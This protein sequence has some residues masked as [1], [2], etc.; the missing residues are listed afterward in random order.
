MGGELRRVRLRLVTVV[1]MI[2][3][4]VSSGAFGIEDMV[5]ESGPGMTMLL[6]LVLP[7]VWGLPMAL[8]CSELGS[9]IPEEGGYYVWV[10]RAMGRFW[11]FQCG[12]WSWTCQWV[13]S[14]V[15]IAL[16]LAYVDGWIPLNSWQRWL[17]GVALIAVFAY[18]N[19]RGLEIV[20]FSS[21]IFSI[22]IL[23]PFVAMVLLGIAQAQVS[24]VSPFVPPGESIFGS[25]GLGLSIGMWMYSGYDSMSVMAGEI[26]EPQRIIP[27]ALMIAVPI[28][29]AAY[30]LP[31]LA[32]LASVDDWS[33]WTTEGGTSFVEVARSLGGRVLGGAMLAAAIVSNIALYVDYLASGSRPAYAMASDNLLPKWLY[34]AHPRY[35][36]PY[37]SIVLLAAI[38]GVLILG[39]F[40]D[41]IVID[42]FL[43]MFYLILIYIAAIRLRQKEPELARPFRIPVGTRA[44]VALSVPP[45]AIAV[46]ALF[47]N[48]TAYMVGGVLAALTGPIAYFIFL[49]IYGGRPAAPIVAEG[50]PSPPS[51]T[52]QRPKARVP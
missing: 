2:F 40:E 7:L 25:L 51:P 46:L 15:Y 23:T 32:G 1:A 39:T 35:G 31:T 9:A 48:G 34:R 3:V 20:A 19:V 52:P 5:S 47:T 33:N 43:N 16:T 38:N 12:W 28:I 10:R 6:L 30:V 41:L 37:L 21:V 14:A 27:R 13:D 4:L 36:T 18:M 44:L 49:R 45:I 42:I 22:V 8:V 29:V 24:P 50:P 11:G 17:V 26:R